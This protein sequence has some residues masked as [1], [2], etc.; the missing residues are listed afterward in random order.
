MPTNTIV[1]KTF[2]YKVPNSMYG[3]SDS[4]GKTV[5]ASYNGPDRCWVFVD[6]DGDEKGKLN[7]MP[8]EWTA[9]ED[10]ET[11]PVP[12]GTTRIEVTVEDDPLVCAILNVGDST[13]TIADQTT[14]EETL[15]DGSKFTYN[16]KPE[17]AETYKQKDDLEYDL[18]AE[19]WKTPAYV[20]APSNWATV[21]NVR[22]S[23]LEAS[24]SK[25]APDQ[26]DA[27]KDPWIA[28]RTKLRDLPATFKKG[29]SDEVDA[30]KVPFP[31]APD[32]VAE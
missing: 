21:I 32:T 19:S 25:I 14:E 2:T 6:T 27:V 23:M 24:D 17:I 13:V 29:E 31:I 18:S 16:G 8:S 28:Y 26:P 30:W 1:T 7:V 5:T 11:L 10:G 15:P 4:D 20:D 3:S 9:E 12:E 22:N